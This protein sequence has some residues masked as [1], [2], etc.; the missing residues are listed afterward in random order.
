M[1]GNH[2]L[3]WYRV[4]RFALVEVITLD[5]SCEVNGHSGIYW[6]TPL[7]V[8]VLHGVAGDRCAIVLDTPLLLGVLGVP[9]LPRWLL[10]LLFGV[11]VWCFLPAP[12]TGFLLFANDL[13]R[14]GVTGVRCLEVLEVCFGVCVAV[15]LILLLRLVFL[16][17]VVD[18]V[19]CLT[20]GIFWRLP[21]ASDGSSSSD[22]SP[23]SPPAKSSEESDGSA[24][25]SPGIRLSR[26]PVL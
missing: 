5:I 17:G 7:T 8:G 6:A 25:A 20:D 11:V 15:L 19:V 12:A 4:C 1:G 24:S 14:S 26:A 3:R 13:L 21:F 22:S 18:G 16:T 2:P 9:D 23:E 10:L